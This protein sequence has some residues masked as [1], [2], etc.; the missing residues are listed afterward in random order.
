MTD[1]CEFDGKDERRFIALEGLVR[2][3]KM[4]PR[5]Q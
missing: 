1:Y 3:L 5:D 2:K 4:G